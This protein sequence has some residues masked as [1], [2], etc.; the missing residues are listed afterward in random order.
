MA[1]N[2]VE[3]SWYLYL[4]EGMKPRIVNAPLS[5]LEGILLI[6]RPNEDECALSLELLQKSISVEID[7]SDVEYSNLTHLYKR[8]AFLKNC[9]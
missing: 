1:K 2:G 4:R 9:R 7:E 5:R 3:V 6:T 8:K